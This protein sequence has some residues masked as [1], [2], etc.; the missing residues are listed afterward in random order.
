MILLDRLPSGND[1]GWKWRCWRVEIENRV[2]RK[3]LRDLPVIESLLNSLVN[4][5]TMPIFLWK[6]SWLQCICAKY[7]HAYRLLFDWSLKVISVC[8]GSKNT[9]RDRG[10]TV[11][12]TAYTVYTV[13][14]VC[15][16]YS[17]YSVYGVCTVYSVQTA[18]HC[19][20][21]SICAYI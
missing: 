20:S 6:L 7:D 17:V 1:G 19:L 2:G 13:Y 12:Y 11:L 4:I 3:P 16:I 10:S 5:M 8:W 15:T 18:L 9:I 14:T 21:S